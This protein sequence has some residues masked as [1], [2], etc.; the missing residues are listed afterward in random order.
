[1]IGTPVLALSCV[2]PMCVHARA[3]VPRVTSSAKFKPASPLLHTQWA[4]ETHDDMNNSANEFDIEPILLSQVSSGTARGRDSGRG[5][6]SL[7]RGHATGEG[8]AEGAQREAET[9]L[10]DAAKYRARFLGRSLSI[11]RVA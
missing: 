3:C 7:H 1:M 5:S 2:L 11:F 8:A 4:L 10:R 9:S 6:Y